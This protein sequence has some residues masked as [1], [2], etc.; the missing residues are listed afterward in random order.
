VVDVKYTAPKARRIKTVWHRTTHDAGAYGT[1]LLRAFLTQ[2]RKFPFPKS[3]YVVRD[4]L[5]AVVGA[6][7]NAL[8]VDFFA[9]SGTTLHA[10]CLLNQEDGGRRRC[11]LVTNN[12]VDPETKQRLNQKGQYRGTPEYEK[13]GIFEAVT[14][15]RCE[16]A[17]N[18]KSSDG[19]AIAGVYLDGR[20]YAD[21]F[22]ENV[23][24]FR[25]DYLDGDEV[26]LGHCFDSIHPLLWLAAGGRGRRPDL[27]ADTPF[28]IAPESGYAVLFR[29]EAFSDFEEALAAHDGIGNVSLV[30]DSEEAFAE[31]RE[32]I[33]AGRATVML[34]R[35]FLRH[36]RRRLR[37]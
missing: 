18:G 16:A 29:E 28:L 32:R 4:A 27:A 34:Y 21:G 25:L 12:E 17:I 33:G 2:G 9:G 22:E 20:R 5:A 14:R 35:D 10:T 31:M 36:Y 7:P 11:I 3:L 37:F 23:E 24:F 26:E 6:N 30:T 15:P 19:K 8:I 13:H 1:G